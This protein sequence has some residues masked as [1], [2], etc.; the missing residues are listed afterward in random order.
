MEVLRVPCDLRESHAVLGIDECSVGWR[1]RSEPGHTRSRGSARGFSRKHGAR[2]GPG[3]AWESKDPPH[4]FRFPM[5]QSVVVG[6]AVHAEPR[7]FVATLE[8]VRRHTPGAAVVAIPDSPDAETSVALARQPELHL[9]PRP[10]EVGGAAC[11]NRLLGSTDA[12][13][14]V[15]LEN[16]CLVS[17]GWLDRLL[18]GLAADPRNG[19]AG[20]STNRAWNEQQAEPRCVGSDAAVAEAA[21]RL[22]RHGRETRTLEPLHSLAD[23]CYAVRREVWDAIGAA[24]EGYGPGPCWEMDYNARAARAGWRGVWVP[25]AF[26]WRPPLTAR[27]ARDERRFFEAGRRRYQDRLCAL[28]LRGGR[29]PYEPHCRGDACEHFAPAGLIQ[30]RI[31]PRP[32]PP[33]V[34]IA[35]TTRPQ[36]DAPA[37]AA[38]GEPP[39]I[40]CIMPTRGRT[41]YALQAVRYFQAQDYPRLELIIVDDAGSDLRRRLPADPRIRYDEV[42]AGWSIGAKRN[43]AVEWARG[44]IVA[45]WDDDDWYAPQRLR[46]QAAPIL[47]GRADVTALRA[48]VFF[49]LERWEFWGCTPALHRRL[50]VSDVVGGTLMYRRRVWGPRASYPPTSLAE[51]AAFLTRAVRGGARLLRVDEPGLYV[52]LRHGS[53]TWRFACGGHVDPAGWIRI[54][55]PPCLAPDRE[56]YRVRSAAARTAPPAPPPARRVRIAAGEAPLVSCLMPTA[57]RRRFVPRAIELFLRQDY[58][59]RELVIVDDGRDAVEDL[60]PADPRIRYVRVERSATLGA[61]RNL[62]CSL[63]RGPLL[64]HWDDDDWTADDRLSRQVAAIQSSGADVCGLSVVR[65]F[66]PV[67]RLAWEYRW[68]DGS[69][70]WVGGNTLLYRRTAWERHPFP[71]LNVGEDTRWVWAQPS[72]HAMTDSRFFAAL[73]HPR[74]TSQKQTRGS[75]WHP[76]PLSLVEAE[77]GEDWTFYAA[78]SREPASV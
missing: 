40:S 48:H 64:A 30:L 9:L 63:A 38:N 74:N 50:F 76:I 59:A 58:A 4:L 36:A 70:P 60:V 20:P 22:A 62:A 44:E 6:I 26:V 18:E 16:G 31:E 24:D 3:L 41:E 32:A 27:R 65:Y 25:A 33:P 47:E 73:V 19:L 37:D 39:L 71:G 52:Y 53:N 1:K 5:N 7:R 12:A 51:D 15:L 46:V 72:V 34:P 45:Q 28:R 66:D 56:F 2:A 11:L 17:P 78:A 69:R 23:F 35:P 42:P 8:S 55:E 54:D 43:R 68:T 61:K 14:C 57:N 49:D 29:G 13:V 67:Q 75:R 21:G 77:M 10:D